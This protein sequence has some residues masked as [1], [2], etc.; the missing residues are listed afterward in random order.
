MLGKLQTYK[1]QTTKFC[2]KGHWCVGGGGQRTPFGIFLT[3][4][5]IFKFQTPFDSSVREVSEQGTKIDISQT[6]SS[7]TGH[8]AKKV[9]QKIGI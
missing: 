5:P 6:G 7:Q 8:Q 9:K 3:T 4:G 1:L 2:E